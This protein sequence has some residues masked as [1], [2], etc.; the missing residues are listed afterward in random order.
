MAL[1]VLGFPC[2]CLDSA[3]PLP[4]ASGRGFPC[5]ALYSPSRLPVYRFPALPC[6]IRGI[7]VIWPVALTAG[8]VSCLAPPAIRA[9]RPPGLCL[10]AGRSPRLPPL[11]CAWFVLAP[12]PRK[13]DPAYG[14]E[15]FVLGEVQHRPGVELF[16]LAEGHQASWPEGSVLAEG[17]LACFPEVLCLA[18]VGCLPGL[19][20]CAWP[21]VAKASSPKVPCL[22]NIP[23]VALPR[24]LPAILPACHLGMRGY[25]PL[26][27]A[28]PV[29]SLVGF[30]GCASGLPWL[31]GMHL[32]PALDYG[33]HVATNGLRCVPLA[34]VPYYAY[35]AHSTLWRAGVP[36]TGF[37]LR[38]LPCN[39]ALLR[40]AVGLGRA[41]PYGLYAFPTGYVVCRSCLWLPWPVCLPCGLMWPVRLLYGLR[42]LRISPVVYVACVSYM[43][44]P[45][46][47]GLIRGYIR[48]Y[49]CGVPAFPCLIPL[50]QRA[51][52]GA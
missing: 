34:C 28:Y 6:T 2:T 22:A 37:I 15:V 47:V 45:W 17:R 10:G 33:L 21:R 40:L 18:K 5:T 12:L 42:G 27:R 24:A 48:G 39:R 38:R 44:L 41:L 8:R 30:L 29:A 31:L 32:W 49:P 9:Y 20:V 50:Y 36:Y 25:L 19:R 16:V 43:R 23:R 3:V 52:F 13:A 11:P 14:C 46:P 26:Q 51:L 35:P 7:R 1:F 4:G